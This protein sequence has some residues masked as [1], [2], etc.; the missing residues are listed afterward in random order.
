MQSCKYDIRM[1]VNAVFPLNPLGIGSETLTDTK[2]QGHSSP[3]Q[4]MAWYLHTAHTHPP[5]YF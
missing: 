3:L 2:N 4:K 5:I 1:E